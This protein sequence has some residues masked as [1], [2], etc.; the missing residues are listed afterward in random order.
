MSE[1]DKKQGGRSRFQ[2]TYVRSKII[3]HS[4]AYEF[5]SWYIV[6]ELNEN[7]TLNKL[8]YEKERVAII[9]Y[10]IEG[11]QFSQRTDQKDLQV[12]KLRL[13]I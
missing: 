5:S 2:A 1:R 4:T 11:R 13:Q 7:T 6:E 12:S 8:V 9:T 10:A 3:F